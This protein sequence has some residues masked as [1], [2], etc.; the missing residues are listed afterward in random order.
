MSY[1][2]VQMSPLATSRI[3]RGTITVQDPWSALRG[4][5]LD[6]AFLRSWLELNPDVDVNDFAPSGRFN[7][8]A[9]S[10]LAL[11]VAISASFWAGV[12]WTVS[13]VWR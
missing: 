9:I 4:S 10:G 13:H 3:A 11:T 6:L 5:S 2:V 7:W 1:K 8:G 12:A